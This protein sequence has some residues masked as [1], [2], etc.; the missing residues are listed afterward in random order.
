MLSYHNNDENRDKNKKYRWIIS[1]DRRTNKLYVRRTEMSQFK[2]KYYCSFS[3]LGDTF[4][5]ITH[6]VG[7]GAASYQ[8]SMVISIHRFHKFCIHA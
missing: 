6:N 5:K 3:M 2:D 7:S 8:D 1:Y 4:N